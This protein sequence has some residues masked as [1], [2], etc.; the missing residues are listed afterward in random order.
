LSDDDFLLLHDD[1]V[2]LL[3]HVFDVFD[4]AVR[5]RQARRGL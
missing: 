5:R 2:V 1:H 4:H 3:L